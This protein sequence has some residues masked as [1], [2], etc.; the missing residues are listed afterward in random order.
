MKEKILF[1]LFF[2]IGLF[3]LTQSYG[4]AQVFSEEEPFIPKSA[5]ELAA[6]AGLQ[7]TDTL[8]IGDIESVK[9]GKIPL[10]DTNP[11]T[12]GI[13]KKPDNVPLVPPPAQLKILPKIDF[14]EALFQSGITHPYQTPIFERVFEAG[15]TDR[16]RYLPA[17]LRPV[18]QTP[19]S[20]EMSKKEPQRVKPNK[21]KEIT[22]KKTESAKHPTRG[23]G[24]LW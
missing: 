16:Y 19:P 8:V 3:F 1:T 11:M 13:L 22:R 2:Y 10:A 9:A 5:A 7:I 20:T 15:N 23:K 6:L 14:D 12:Y 4:Q 24:K 17:P 18:Y 21:P